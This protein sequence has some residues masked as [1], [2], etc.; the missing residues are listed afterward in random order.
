MVRES[1]AG[2]ATH[3]RPLFPFGLAF[4]TTS[5]FSGSPVSRTGYGYSV[6]ARF[7]NTGHGPGAACTPTSDIHR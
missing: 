1:Y 4:D 7:T 5:G 2:D 3:Q 6:T